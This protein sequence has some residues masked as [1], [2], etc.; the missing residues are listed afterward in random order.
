LLLE[1]IKRKKTH[2]ALICALHFVFSNLNAQ[3][4]N[5]ETQLKEVEQKVIDWR[6]DIHQNPELGNREFR[7]AEMVA[8]TS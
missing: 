4:N 1:I 6:R 5:L 7:T 8:K 2:L 3:S